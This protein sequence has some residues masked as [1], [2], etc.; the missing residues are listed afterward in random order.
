MESQVFPD[1]PPFGAV[2]DVNQTKIEIQKEMAR[3]GQWKPKYAGYR[4]FGPLH[5]EKSHQLVGPLYD[6]YQRFQQADLPYPGE[7]KLKSHLG[8]PSRQKPLRFEQLAHYTGAKTLAKGHK[9]QLSPKIKSILETPEDFELLRKLLNAPAAQRAS[10]KT[11]RLAG[12][13]NKCS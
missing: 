5:T 1:G 4:L 12:H 10:K 13:A 7:A 6:L 3:W 11:T 8:S 2:L 9:K